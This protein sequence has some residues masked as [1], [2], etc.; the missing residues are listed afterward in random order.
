MG[1]RETLATVGDTYEV[2]GETSRALTRR[3]S[4]IPTRF[5]TLEFPPAQ[6]NH[7]QARPRGQKRR[8]PRAKRT[9]VE[10]EE[11]KTDAELLAEFVRH[12]RSRDSNWPRDV[13]VELMAGGSP[14]A[15]Y[16]NRVR[17]PGRWSSMAFD[18]KSAAQLAKD[19][20]FADLLNQDGF[21]FVRRNV[22]LMTLAELEDELAVR[23]GARLADV[24]MLVLY[25]DCTTFSWAS[26]SSATDH[27]SLEG[28]P[29][30]Y[31]A[32]NHTAN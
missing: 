23:I 18:I 4:V 22:G 7:P 19:P 9:V 13:S 15:Q 27:R 12:E 6:P 30:S 29:K 21:H 16:L 31:L 10:P 3:P 2:D 20:A 8:A 14:V 25:M 28:A 1:F 11:E 17:S 32:Q 5:H 24:T 26:L